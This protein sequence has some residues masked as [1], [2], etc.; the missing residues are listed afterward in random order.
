[1]EKVKIRRKNARARKTSLRAIAVSP[2]FLRSKILL[3]FASVVLHMNYAQESR[4]EAEN[5]R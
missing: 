3:L 1:V 2:F 4:E 5:F